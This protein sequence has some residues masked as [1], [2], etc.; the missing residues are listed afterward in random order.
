MTAI[1]REEVRAALEEGQ[2][3][4]TWRKANG[5]EMTMTC[6]LNVEKM[7]RAITG[8]NDFLAHEVAVRE[9]NPDLQ[10]VWS[11]T[12]YGWKSFHW[13]RLVSWTT[14]IPAEDPNPTVNP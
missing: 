11:I 9:A 8:T 12:D 6:T 4:V 5:K 10:A 3:F 14:D 1:N 13:D 2:I 7:G